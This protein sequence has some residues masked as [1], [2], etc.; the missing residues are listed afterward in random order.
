MAKFINQF[1]D[2]HQELPFNIHSSTTKINLTKRSNTS[3]KK[4]WRNWVTKKANHIYICF[5]LVTTYT[6]RTFNEIHIFYTL[7][8]EKLPWPKLGTYR[9]PVLHPMHAYLP[10][11]GHLHQ[12]A[13]PCRRSPGTITFS[14]ENIEKETTN[15]TS[16]PK[17]SKSS[18][19]LSL[20]QTC[21]RTKPSRSSSSLS[22]FQTRKR[23]SLSPC[24][25]WD[26]RVFATRGKGSLEST[27]LPFDHGMAT[28]PAFADVDFNRKVDTPSQLKARV[29]CAD[30]VK[31]CSTSA[32]KHQKYEDDLPVDCN[33]TR[34]AILI[35]IKG[36]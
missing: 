3:Q 9:I 5:L 1:F 16:L 33:Q 31:Q 28:C 10:I 22:S 25:S 18:S 17:P 32:S 11:Y 20:F 14:S 6:W 23:R 7:S 27:L 13:L 19:S 2:R 4:W 8:M 21:K 36:W 26:E 30:C 24:L 29:G 35:Q 12:D 34:V 15:T